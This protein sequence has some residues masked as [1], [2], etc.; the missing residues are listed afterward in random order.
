MGIGQKIKDAITPGTHK[1]DT[2]EERADY[3]ATAPGM[4]SGYFR[5]ALFP[6]APSDC[7]A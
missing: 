5:V 3:A 2:A 7:T 4:V 1:H 6:S